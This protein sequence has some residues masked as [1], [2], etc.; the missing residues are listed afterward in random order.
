LKK[1]QLRI[2]F[3]QLHHGA[4]I[5]CSG[6]NKYKS[7]IGCGQNALNKTWKGFNGVYIL[8]RK[9]NISRIIDL[10]KVDLV[11]QLPAKGKKSIGGLRQRF[12]PK[13]QSR[14]Y[15]PNGLEICV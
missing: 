12:C 14:L 10:R 2:G 13:G 4:V 7:I 3:Y 15:V 9:G 11:A 8:P 6:S 1:E 5:G